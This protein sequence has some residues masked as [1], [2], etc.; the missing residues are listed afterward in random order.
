MSEISTTVENAPIAAPLVKDQ[1]GSDS[2]TDTNTDTDNEL[3]GIDLVDKISATIIPVSENV[4]LKLPNKARTTFDIG[5]VTIQTVNILQ[6]TAT[7][8][9]DQLNSRTVIKS[10]TPSSAIANNNASSQKQHK[11][12]APMLNYIF[13]SHST[14]KHSHYDPRYRHRLVSRR[15]QL[16]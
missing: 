3:E 12:D 9:R 1:H 14:N 4:P 6:R 8:S 11:P 2:E 10:S 16:E 5:T 15:R 13:D 7:V